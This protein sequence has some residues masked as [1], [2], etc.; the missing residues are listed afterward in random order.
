MTQSWT[1]LGLITLFFKIF[2]LNYKILKIDAHKFN[3]K[4]NIRMFIWDCDNLI[5]NKP[6][7]IIKTN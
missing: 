1:L 4:P 5:E 2:L 6:K 7:Q 3:Y